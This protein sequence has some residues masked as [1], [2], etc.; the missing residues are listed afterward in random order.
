MSERLCVVC[1]KT[2]NNSVAATLYEL[3]DRINTA[4]PHAILSD[5]DRPPT[6]PVNLG[7][8]PEH[9]EYYK[10]GLIAVIEI[11]TVKN[12]EEY[13]AMASQAEGRTGN[14][15]YLPREIIQ[16]LANFPPRNAVVF[17]E[18]E[19]FERIKAASKEVWS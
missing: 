4:T 3:D 8:C 16:R 14:M 10:E 11:D 5:P 6:R 13:D 17:C 15:L 9:Q 1:L 19:P 2:C 18:R 12:Q 7:L